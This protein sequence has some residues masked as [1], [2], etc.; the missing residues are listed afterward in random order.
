MTIFQQGF[1]ATALLFGV[2]GYAYDHHSHNKHYHSKASKAAK[3][4]EAQR[5]IKVIATD[6]M[7]FQFKP[8]LIEKPIQLNEIITFQVENKGALKHEFSIDDVHGTKIHRAMMQKNPNMQHTD[9]NT[10][11]L[12]AGESGTL[13]RQFTQRGDMVFSCN[14]AGHYEGGMYQKQQVK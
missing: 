12:K 3:P 10:L 8:S 13:T 6:D 14:E 11:V 4:T 7:R 5:V 1:I 2:H 9:S